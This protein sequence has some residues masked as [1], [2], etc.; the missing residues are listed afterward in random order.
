[1][2]SVVIT[3]IIVIVIVVVTICDSGRDHD[4]DNHVDHDDD[5]FY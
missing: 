3:V 5:C 4:G 2:Q 1:M